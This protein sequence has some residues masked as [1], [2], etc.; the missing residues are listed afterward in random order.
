MF[1]TSWEFL[2][3]IMQE[4]KAFIVSDVCLILNSIISLLYTYIL[5]ALYKKNLN[6]TT[7][8]KQV[9]EHFQ[10]AAKFTTI[11]VVPIVG[12]ISM[13][14][15]ERLLKQRPQAIV[16][17]PGRLWE[18]MSA[19]EQFL[20]EVCPSITQEQL[21]SDRWDILTFE[22]SNIFSMKN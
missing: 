16:G 18:F 19:G 3:I 10:A 14:K 13:E 2:A 4:I 7:A 8:F 1:W 6:A 17:T 15:Q 21:L 5:G 22:E 11:K 12:G 9:C 20:T